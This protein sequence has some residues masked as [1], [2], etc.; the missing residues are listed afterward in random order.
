MRI[1]FLS[2]R[3]SW[4]ANS[5]AK[6][7]DLYL[8]R[9]L[10]QAADLTYLFFGDSTAAAELERQL[11]RAHNVVPPRKYSAA[12]ILRGLIGSQP[13]PILNY[14]SPEMADAISALRGNAFDI[15]HLDSIHMAGY[16]S[17]IRECW[18][19]AIVILDWHNIE[20]EGMLRF[21]ESTASLPRR[22]Y[23]RYTAATLRRV[24]GRLL[25]GLQGHLVCSDRE[26]GLLLARN[27]KARIAVIDNG[28]DA[29][30]FATASTTPSNR[31]IFVGQMGYGPNADGAVWFVNEIWPVVRR[32]FPALSLFLVGA[33]PGPAVRALSAQPGVT[34]TGTVPD[35]RSYYEGALAAVVP[36]RTGAGTRLKILEAMGAGVPVI[37]TSIGAE[38][39]AVQNGEDILIAEDAAGWV[40]AL[41][42]ISQP[43][44]AHAFAE[45]GRRLV[46][47]RYDWSIIGRKLARCYDDWT[48]A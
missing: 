48:S 22:F 14:T 46:S 31:L 6:L 43:D 18:P 36:L 37:S 3:Q 26:R 33:D 9:G 25:A 17:V 47:T 42:R 20:S 12:K 11:G 10:A 45:A 39:L 1:L 19:K 44:T 8:A 21:A 5:G 15:V 32:G 34:V 28:V 35:V 40:A 27:P 41:E 4:P 13:L 7:R 23:G 30:G 29:A 24:E 38:G 2:P 16:L